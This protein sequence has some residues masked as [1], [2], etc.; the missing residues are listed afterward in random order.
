MILIKMKR[1]M[2]TKVNPAL[3]KVM[4]VLGIGGFIILA[5]IISLLSV[6]QPASLQRP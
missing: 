2:M 1:M 6:M 3:N 5:V 4:M